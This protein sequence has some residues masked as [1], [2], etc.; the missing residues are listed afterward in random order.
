MSSFLGIISIT[1]AQNTGGAFSIGQGSLITVV[2][3]NFI[4]LGII[5]RFFILQFQKMDK[6]TKVILCLVLAGGISNLID[7]L[8]R[9]FVVDYIDINS[10]LSFPIFNLADIYVVIG[11]TMLIL[12]TIHYTIKETKR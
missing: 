9:G 12:I 8:V 1:Y 6:I 5:I 2:L 3:V 7:R 4:V 10:W 11:W